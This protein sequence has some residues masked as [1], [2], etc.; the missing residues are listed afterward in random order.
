MKKRPLRRA[1]PFDPPPPLG[2]TR[3]TA[4]VP[5]V[6]TTHTAV[7]LVLTI[8]DGVDYHAGNRARLNILLRSLDRALA[9][10][11]A[12]RPADVTKN[13]S[14]KGSGREVP[15]V[16]VARKRVLCEREPSQYVGQC[17]HSTPRSQS[18]SYPDGECNTLCLHDLLSFPQGGTSR[19]LRRVRK[20]NCRI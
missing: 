18:E 17:R 13:P 7:P 4:R 20:R 5:R 16:R 15:D 14:V 12:D 10:N 9:P 11:P 19:L 6:T 2:D 1:W 8:K 3:C